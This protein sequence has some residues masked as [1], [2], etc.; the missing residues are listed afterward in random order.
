MP[1]PTAAALALELCEADG[2]SNTTALIFPSRWQSKGGLENGV[3]TMLAEIHR[4]FHT[5]SGGWI[6]QESDWMGQVSHPDVKVGAGGVM[7]LKQ[8]VE[9][10]Y[11]VRLTPDSLVLPDGRTFPRTAFSIAPRFGWAMG[12]Y[13]RDKLDQVQILAKEDPTKSAWQSEAAILS[14]TRGVLAGLDGLSLVNWPGWSGLAT[15]VRL[16]GEHAQPALAASGKVSKRYQATAGEKG[17]KLAILLLRCWEMRPDRGWMAQ[18]WIYAP[19][20]EPQH[21]GLFAAGKESAAVLRTHL[22]TWNDIRALHANS[23]V[24]HDLAPALRRAMT[25]ML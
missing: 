14:L 12:S 8:A 22:P 11:A 16:A 18:R 9:G 15:L 20:E 25:G 23:P 3:L 13:S 2:K 7:F 4:P 5:L 17:H 1:S 21:P 6:A 24:W 19:S 10:A